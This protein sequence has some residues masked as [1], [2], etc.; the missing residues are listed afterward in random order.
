MQMFL[1]NVKKGFT[2]NM[3]FFLL[4]LGLKQLKAL[5]CVACYKITNVRIQADQPK[6]IF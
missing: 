4:I 1:L 3:P 5:S 2:C 6:N